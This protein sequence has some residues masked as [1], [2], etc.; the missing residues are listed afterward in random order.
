MMWSKFKCPSCGLPLA[1]ILE[2]DKVSLYCSRLDCKSQEMNAGGEGDT[3]QEA[4]DS[5]EMTYD[6]ATT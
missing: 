3:E 4:F 2:G 5:L 1:R 6:K